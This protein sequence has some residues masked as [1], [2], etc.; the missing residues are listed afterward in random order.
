MN[1]V[2][3]AIQWDGV[4][5]TFELFALHDGR[6]PDTDGLDFKIVEP[7]K[8]ITSLCLE[9]EL[10]VLGGYLLK[11]YDIVTYSMPDPLKDFL[12][13]CS[14]KVIRAGAIGC[15][16]QFSG[17]FDF[18]NLLT[19]ESFDQIYFIR[20]RDNYDF[21]LEDESICSN[22]WKTKISEFRKQLVKEESR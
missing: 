12:L 20:H 15:W 5:S 4:Y 9:D 8:P 13:Y 6:R 22:A 14:T 1:Q 21:A 7:H 2:L 11:S 17:S 16:F 19:P 3:E 10:G 18:T